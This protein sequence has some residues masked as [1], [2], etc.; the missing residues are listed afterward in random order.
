[1]GVEIADQDRWDLTSEKKGFQRK[2]KNVKINRG[3]RGGN[4]TV[5]K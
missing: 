3:G 1:M 2:I 4:V 5:K